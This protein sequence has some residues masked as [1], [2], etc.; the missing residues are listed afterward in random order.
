MDSLAQSRSVCKDDLKYFKLS[1]LKLLVPE[2][3]KISTH[4]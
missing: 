3:N 4:Q 2:K 1:L